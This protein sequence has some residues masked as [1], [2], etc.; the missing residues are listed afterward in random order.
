MKR[1]PALLLLAALSAAA[2]SAA[3]LP[4]AASPFLSCDPF[5][6]TGIVPTHFGVVMDGGAKV[7]S[8]AV[9]D[10]AGAASCRFDLGGL[11]AGD[12]TVTVTSVIINPVWGRAES[13]ATPPFTFTRPSPPKAPSHIT[14]S[15]G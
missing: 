3:A 7:D 15:P 4:A 6:A 10:A 12:H 8:P 5:P 14:I 2:L 11:A 1:P 13:A 9:L